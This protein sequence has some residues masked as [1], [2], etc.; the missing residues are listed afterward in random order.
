MK[1]CRRGTD[2]FSWW[3]S[4]KRCQLSSSTWTRFRVYYELLQRPERE[5]RADKLYVRDDVGKFL[6]CNELERKGKAAFFSSS[7]CHGTHRMECMACCVQRQRA[8]CPPVRPG[9]AGLR[10]RDAKANNSAANGA[11][12]TPLS[13]GW[14]PEKRSEV[15]CLDYWGFQRHEKYPVMF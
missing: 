7:Q 2:F 15:A 1:T 5:K 6:L 3:R 13:I 14:E 4:E 10:S 11:Q 8:M 12:L 9:S